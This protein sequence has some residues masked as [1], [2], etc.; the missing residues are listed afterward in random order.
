MGDNAD[1]SRSKVQ[2]PAQNIDDRP[3]SPRI[4]RT[5]PEPKLTLPYG[6]CDCHFHFIG[7]Q[8]QFPMVPN[9]PFGNLQFE[10]TSFED[11]EKMQGGLGLTRGLHVESMMYGRNYELALHAACRYPDRLRTV[12]IMPWPEITDRELQILTDAGVVGARISWMT[13]K[14]VSKQMLERLNELGWSIH[15]LIPMVELDELWE[16]LILNSPGNFIL[17]H[18]GYPP[19]EKGANSEEFDFVIKCLDT[20][21]CWVKLSPRFSGQETFPFDDTYPFVT[22]LLDAAPNRLLWGSDW[23]HPQYFKPMP[24]DVALLDMVLDWI[25]DETVRNMIFV[26]NPAELFGFT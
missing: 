14:D 20:G 7:P 16:D 21:R 10:D 1:L 11:W 13:E 9:R 5:Y 15:Y 18:N 24:N 19:V 2:E 4:D 26:D 22:R 6:A 3:F 17:E 25:P 23:P 8:S 12:V